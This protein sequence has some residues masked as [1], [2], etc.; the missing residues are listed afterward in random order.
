MMCGAWSPP[1]TR[2]TSWGDYGEPP[3]VPGDGG[4]SATAGTGAPFP[5]RFR[6][7]PQI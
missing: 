7:D 6:A 5:A 2:E 4:K 1:E 3:A